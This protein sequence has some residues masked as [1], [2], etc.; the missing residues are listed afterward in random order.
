MDTE[1]PLLL[2]AHT[3]SELGTTQQQL[4]LG[5]PSIHYGQTKVRMDMWGE[6]HQQPEIEQELGPAKIAVGLSA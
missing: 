3:T 6:E 5:Q 4:D 2:L 1:Q